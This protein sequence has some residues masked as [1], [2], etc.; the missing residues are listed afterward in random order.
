VNQPMHA[1]VF[2]YILDYWHLCNYRDFSLVYGRAKNG[3]P[4]YIIL[5]VTWRRRAIFLSIFTPVYS[6]SSSFI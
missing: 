3:L 6:T 4:L 5:T 1:D 2:T